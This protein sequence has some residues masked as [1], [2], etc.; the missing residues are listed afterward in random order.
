[1][2]VNVNVLKLHN[3]TKKCQELISSFE[4]E[5][6]NVKK[7]VSDMGNVWKGNDYDFFSSNMSEFLEELKLLQKQMTSYQKFLVGY[8]ESFSKLNQIYGSKT[9]HLK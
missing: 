6:V 5:L 2:Y 4:A 8:L 1:M 3:E 9:I 7:V